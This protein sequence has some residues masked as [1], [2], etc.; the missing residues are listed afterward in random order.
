LLFEE[1]KAAAVGAVETPSVAGPRILT[2]TGVIVVVLS[3]SD[4]TRLCVSMLA[5][6][7]NG[8]KFY[9]LSYTVY[10]AS[11]GSGADSNP[12]FFD[13]KVPKF[14]STCTQELVKWF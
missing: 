2:T 3:S 4:V 6:D 7:C 8:G 11:A 9:F 13:K 1:S 5:V 12:N 10:S 14:E